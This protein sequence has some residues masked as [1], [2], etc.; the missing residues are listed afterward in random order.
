MLFARRW[1][2][3]ALWALALLALVGGALY[4]RTQSGFAEDFLPAYGA[5]RSLRILGDPYAASPFVP[6]VYP[7]SSALLLWPLGYLGQA[8]AGDVGL[9]VACASLAVLACTS[10]A[11]AGERAS[12]PWAAAVVLVLAATNLGYGTVQ[13]G[14]L[15][16]MVVAL[17]AVALLLLCRGRALPAAAALGVAIAF[18][19]LVGP[20]VLVFAMGRRWRA[21]AVALVVPAALNVLALPLLESPTTYVRQVLPSLVSGASVTRAHNVALVGWGRRAGA[22]EALVLTFRVAVI[23]LAVA[24]CLRAARLGGSRAVVL[25][26]TVPVLAVAVASGIDESHYSL[27]AVPLLVALASRANPV[28]TGIVLLSAVLVT[29]SA[30]AG[31]QLIGQLLA[32]V[33]A[34]LASG[35]A[36]PDGE[37]KRISSAV[38]IRS[39]P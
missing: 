13:L 24:V 37:A 31:L 36:G 12:G 4:S 30:T 6:F 21:L 11:L 39:A 1:G 17:L 8:A 2:A 22:P 35:S 33:A 38:A 7:P 23:G 25:W 32:L 27:V 34:G 9:L 29:V 18:K 14:N 5:A 10:V 16:V 3:V 26:G 20:A 19:P 15:T 28:R